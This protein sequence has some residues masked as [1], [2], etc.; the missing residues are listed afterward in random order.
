MYKALSAP[1]ARRNQFRVHFNRENM[2]VLLCILRVVLIWA[3][4]LTALIIGLYLLYSSAIRGE[5][6]QWLDQP[7]VKRSAEL[8]VLCHAT[9]YIGGR[10]LIG[11]VWVRMP[12][13]GKKGGGRR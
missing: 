6:H 9:Y 8:Y 7:T 13:L 3:V 11:F 4:F 12:R 10:K 2:L 1:V 5:H